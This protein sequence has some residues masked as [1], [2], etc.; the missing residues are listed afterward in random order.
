MPGSKVAAGKEADHMKI[1]VKEMLSPNYDLVQN[2]KHSGPINLME[3]SNE[4]GVLIYAVGKELAILEGKEAFDL[5][6]GKK[7][8]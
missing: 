4:Y 3:F 2:F 6:H 5:T 7:P 1:N 8:N